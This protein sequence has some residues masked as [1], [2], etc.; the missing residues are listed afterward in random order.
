MRIHALVM[1]VFTALPYIH[2]SR[3]AHLPLLEHIGYERLLGQVAREQAHMFLVK[4]YTPMVRSSKKQTKNIKLHK[5]PNWGMLIHTM[6]IGTLSRKGVLFICRYKHTYIHTYNS[7]NA[8]HTDYIHT[9]IHTYITHTY[10]WLSMLCRS[11][12][13]CGPAR[14]AHDGRP[15]VLTPCSATASPAAARTRCEEEC[16]RERC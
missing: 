16:E 13:R 6:Q 5:N 10:T 4:S 3:F 14:G 12:V 1:I 8:M 15:A 7:I 9:C 11:A 2:V